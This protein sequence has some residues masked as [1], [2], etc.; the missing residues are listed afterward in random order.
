MRAGAAG[1]LALLLALASCQ[2]D[3]RRSYRMQSTAMEPTIPLKS[4]FLVRD[5]APDEWPERG[6]VV[7]CERAEHP[8]AFAATRVVALG[9]D[10]V[11]IVDG[12]L[13][14]NGHSVR[15]PY[16]APSPPGLLAREP[17]E[18]P[19]NFPATHIPSGQIFVLGDNR[20]A[21]YDS[22]FF[23]PIDAGLVKG[24]VILQDRFDSSTR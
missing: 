8:G 20:D 19:R 5:P 18:A 2:G 21:S 17:P 16:L 24:Y 12:Q 9:G 6:D 15:E 10:Q 22:R 23:G 3:G 11:E 14:V 4:M 7:V 1:A 13:R